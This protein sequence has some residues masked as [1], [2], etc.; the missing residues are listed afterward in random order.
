MFAACCFGLLWN[1]FVSNSHD[2]RKPG[3]FYG[4]FW[5]LG[6]HDRSSV[7]VHLGRN[8][9]TSSEVELTVFQ[10]RTRRNDDAAKGRVS[11][12]PPPKLETRQLAVVATP[13]PI[14]NYTS[15]PRTASSQQTTHAHT[16]PLLH[17][18]AYHGLLR[19]I[20]STSRA[21]RHDAPAPFA[22]REL[23][24]A[25]ALLTRFYVQPHCQPG[26]WCLHGARWHCPLLSDSHVR[27]APKTNAILA[28]VAWMKRS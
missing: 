5:P 17:I 9:R 14:A 25:I 13:D 28:G 23:R 7:Y 22:Y 19:C 12:K 21:S 26:S 3:L 16:H 11:S 27:S 24:T 10:P 15:L 20:V 2:L 1:S 6:I 4:V 8:I 18:F